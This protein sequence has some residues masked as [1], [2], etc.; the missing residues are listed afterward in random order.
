MNNG[1][2][3]K[4]YVCYLLTDKPCTISFPPKAQTCSPNNRQEKWKMFKWKMFLKNPIKIIKGLQIRPR[5]ILHQYLFCKKFGP[6]SHL[7]FALFLLQNI[8]L[9]NLH[10]LT[11]MPWLCVQDLVCVTMETINNQP[12]PS[13]PTLVGEKKKI[14]FHFNFLGIVEAV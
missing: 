11:C 14:W 9:H 2:H 7:Q 4:D 6:F 10:A 3:W 5:E 12:I 1:V 13:M 8:I